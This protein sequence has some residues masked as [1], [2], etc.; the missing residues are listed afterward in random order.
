MTSKAKLPIVRTTRPL[1]TPTMTNSENPFAMSDSKGVLRTFANFSPDA[2]TMVQSMSHGLGESQTD[3]RFETLSNISSSDMRRNLPLD[4]DSLS[5]CGGAPDDEASL[6][7]W[8]HPEEL[9]Y[10][11]E[12]PIHDPNA[13]GEEQGLSMNGQSERRDGLGLPSDANSSA[14]ANIHDVELNERLD[15][16]VFNA[17]VSG[18]EKTLQLPWDSECFS[19]IF[20][21][22]DSIYPQVDSDLV[23]FENPSQS[24]HCS[25]PG[26]VDDFLKL[27]HVQN[28]FESAISFRAGRTRSMQLEAQF[29]IMYQ[30]WTVLVLMNPTASS[31]GRMLMEFAHGPCFWR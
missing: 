29:D 19:G 15:R 20:A 1:M 10:L 5:E 25:I 8:K 16:M 4:I 17:R 12:A 26:P 6:S 18:V 27:D 24:T 9:P 7:S 28:C 14:D 13:L 21:A 22:S 31:T 30:R 11:D 23:C 3:D 2:D